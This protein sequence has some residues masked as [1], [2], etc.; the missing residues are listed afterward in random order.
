MPRRMPDVR[1]VLALTAFLAA[2]DGAPA[3][4]PPADAN[5]DPPFP[6]VHS[7]APAVADGPVLMVEPEPRLEVGVLE[8]DPEHR[9]DRVRGVAV[10]D[11]G[12]VVVA[13]GGD[14]TVRFYDAAGAL[15]ETAGGTGGGPSELRGVT[16]LSRVGD[17][18]WIRNDPHGYRIYDPSGA[19]VGS[20][21][22][23]LEPP[24]DARSIRARDVFAD[25]SVLLEAGPQ[26]QE[27]EGARV[28]SVR[29]LRQAAPGV[30]LAPYAVVPAARYGPGAD[31]S[32]PMQRFGPLL[33]LAVSGDSLFHGSSDDHEITVRDTAGTVLRRI[34]W[35]GERERVTA[36]QIEGGTEAHAYP[37]RHPA[38][39]R[40]V[41][42]RQGW[43]WVE[44]VHPDDPP[45]GDANPVRSGFTT[46]DVFDGDARW[47]GTVA[48]PPRF[49][50]LE[51]G[52]D[53]VAGV[54]KDALDAELVRVYGL[55]SD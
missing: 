53:Y 41:A 9:L 45:R 34:R 23:P 52:A 30:D 36:S 54:W 38:F 42:T 12:G 8:G 4:S 5:A 51:V 43:L 22:V 46:W 29:L 37:E 50:V 19:L 48:T 33:F 44:R 20:R 26:R 6:V 11:D 31:G 15:V 13:N 16:G 24:Q 14:N 2:C 10:R 1:P 49:R 18:I 47:L 32:D 55:R 21:S 7:A 40:I 28:D 27:G 17:R 39:R 3:D 35:D 25:G